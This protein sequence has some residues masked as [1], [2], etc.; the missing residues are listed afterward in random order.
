MSGSGQEAF[1]ELLRQD[2]GVSDF[3][4]GEPPLLQASD[5]LRLAKHLRDAIGYS[6]YGFVVASHWPGKS[7]DAE[8]HGESTEAFEVA[9]GVRS[10]GNNSHM[11]IWRVRLDA[12]QAM[13]SLAHIYAGADWQEREQ[14]DLVG[15]RFENHPDLRRLM[16]PEDWQGHPLRKDYAIE[17]SCFPWR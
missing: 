15:V 8:G 2:F 16:M 13:P 3:P 10:P 12:D 5:H 7:G 6:I 11:A 14:Y 9:T 4:E 17:T 1:E